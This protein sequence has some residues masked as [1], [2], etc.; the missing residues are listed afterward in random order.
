M[1]F[2][3]ACISFLI[4][5]SS[6]LAQ[7]QKLKVYLDTKQFYAVSLGNFV[8]INF[9]FVG[10]TVEYIGVEGGLQGEIAVLLKIVQN[11][12]TIVTDAYR[13]ETPVMFDSIVEDFYDIRRFA[14]KPGEYKLHLQIFDLVRQ[15]E[16][17][18]G[19]IKF[20]I[21][22]KS[23]NVEFADI[24]NIENAKKGDQSSVFFKSGYEIIPRLSNYYP[25]QLTALPYYTEIYNSNKLNIPE[26]G[27]KERVFNAET[28]L[29]LINYTNI[30]RYATKDVVPV[31]RQIDI[32]ELPTGNYYLSLVV[33]D[34]KM[35]E[36]NEKKYFFERT[37]NESFVLDENIA[38]DPAFELSIPKDSVA[39]YLA[40]LIPIAKGQSTI[41]ILRTLKEKDD[42]KS[43]K[44]IQSFWLSTETAN[45]Y[46]SWLRYKA[47]VQ[48]VEKLFSNTFYAGF[49]SDR[50]RVYL[51][52]GAPTNVTSRIM[53]TEEFPHE[54]WQY[55]KIG[56][57]S[58]RH[59]V[60]YN[61]DMV[62]NSFVLLHSDLIGEKKNM[63][64]PIALQYKD[65][66]NGDTNNQDSG[67]PNTFQDQE[68][69]LFRRN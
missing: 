62:A 9:Q 40:S 22:E 45:A 48:Y 52:Y 43:I 69:L 42:E 20:K 41:T 37:N 26:F 68:N 17:V 30:Y 2:I 18:T 65:A 23:E 55:N 66:F 29:E 4:M 64:W 56:K 53:T 24:Q 34:S 19:T 21:E 5:T 6:G 3:V 50:G 14:L 35:S 47:Q 39:Y 51:Q 12:D 27:L 67:V 46:N 10:P 49:E 28:K 31:L 44:L 63:N 36:I 32:S 61:P 11:S 7:S 33:I 16:P 15:D 25:E 13:L 60:F 1:K 58:N 8:E 54:I 38:L 57:A 59:F